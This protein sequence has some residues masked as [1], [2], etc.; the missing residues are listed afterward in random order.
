MQTLLAGQR[1]LEDPGQQQ[2]LLRLIPDQEVAAQLAA[3]WAAGRGSKVPMG[4]DI[5]L[6]RWRDVQA[7]VEA[8]V[9]RW[10]H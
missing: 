4:G 9:C 10:P 7:A 8:K 6:A 5:S 3:D 2:L 1:V